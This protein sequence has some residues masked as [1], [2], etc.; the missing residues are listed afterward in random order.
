MWNLDRFVTQS[1][2]SHNS[3]SVFGTFCLFIRKKLSLFRP[4]ILSNV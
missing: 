4:K 1:K 3:S 2:L